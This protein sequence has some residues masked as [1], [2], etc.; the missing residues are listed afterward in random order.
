MR[1]L[2][3]DADAIEDPAATAVSRGDDIEM[4][5]GVSITRASDHAAER[6]HV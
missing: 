5:K 4:A 6:T 1:R 2:V 3:E